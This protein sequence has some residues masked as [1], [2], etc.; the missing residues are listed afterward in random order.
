[1]KSNRYIIPG[2]AVWLIQLLL[3]DFLAIKTIR[4]DFLAILILYW[5]IKYGR[6]QG[7]VSGFLIGILIDLSG[8]ASFFGLSPLLYS[9]TGYLG[10]YLKG[11]YSKLNPFY[12]SLA[13]VGI[14]AL[15]FFIFCIVQYQDIW[16]V[17]SQ[18]FWMKWFGTTLYTLCFAGI[19]QVIYPLHR[20]D[21]C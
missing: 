7:T 5:A 18:L 4:P 20:L 12:F 8:T 10:G 3:A 17:D 9:I 16:Y 19:L 21:P 2:V 11:A 6:L 1:M 13:W 14:I 15:Q